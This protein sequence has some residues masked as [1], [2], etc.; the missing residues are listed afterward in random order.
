MEIQFK[1][2]MEGPPGWFSPAQVM[3]SGL[4]AQWRVYLGIL[5][6]FSPVPPTAHTHALSR[7]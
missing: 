3:I 5:S 4:C 2:E 7:K 1:G 6:G